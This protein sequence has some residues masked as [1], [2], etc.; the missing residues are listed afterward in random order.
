MPEVLNRLHTVTAAEAKE[1]RSAADTLGK[2]ARPIRA[3]RIRPEGGA[4]LQVTV[5]PAAFA[6]FL[7]LLRQM[8][9][10]KAVT[11]LPVDAELT[12]QQAADLLNV[13]RPYLIRLLDGKE[14]P[15]HRTG[16]RRKI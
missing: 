6:L 9:Q 2:V 10:G 15:F 13:S 12:T 11:I 16:N 14:L 4:E 3:V 1:A 5:P 8:A 7:E